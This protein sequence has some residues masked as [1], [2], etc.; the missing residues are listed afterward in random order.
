MVVILME[1]AYNKSVIKTHKNLNKSVIK[2]YRNSSKSVKECAYGAIDFE[3]V[4]GVEKFT[5]P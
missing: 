1:T 5:L 2:I 3:E 4:V